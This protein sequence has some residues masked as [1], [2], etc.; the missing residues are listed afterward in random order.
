MAGAYYIFFRQIL[1]CSFLRLNTSDI[2]SFFIFK[3]TRWSIP[4]IYFLLLLSCFYDN[5]NIY[6]VIFLTL[7]IF[8]VILILLEYLFNSVM[9]KLNKR[10]KIRVRYFSSLL[11]FYTLV[12]AGMYAVFYENKD[13]LW[14]KEKR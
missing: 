5:R 14:K 9:N 8:S 12:T 4:V 1:K 7:N 2:L 6:Y 3:V 11:Y 10:K 13:T